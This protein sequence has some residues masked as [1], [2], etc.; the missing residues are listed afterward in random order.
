MPTKYIKVDPRERLPTKSMYYFVETSVGK[1]VAFFFR[2]TCSFQDN[3]EWL[4]DYW[5][6][7]VEG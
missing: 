3:E 5:L 6:E 7:E 1:E 4:I 2:E